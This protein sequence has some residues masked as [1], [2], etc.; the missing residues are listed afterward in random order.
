MVLRLAKDSSHKALLA[1]IIL[2]A[3]VTDWSSTIRFGAEQAKL[4]RFAGFLAELALSSRWGSRALGL[5]RRINFRALDW[6]ESEVAVPTLVIH[7]VSDPVVPITTSRMFC[8]NNPESAE[9]VEF[10]GRQHAWEYN[11]DP[12][13]FEAVVSAWFSSHLANA[14][15][16]NAV[17]SP[18]DIPA[19]TDQESV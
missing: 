13:R 15:Q 1:G 16:E 3:P 6:R 12:Q 17:G 4:P 7:S 8:R 5:P 2:I 18:S 14:N 19:K 11:I 10:P 9:L